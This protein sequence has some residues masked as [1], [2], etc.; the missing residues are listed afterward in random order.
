LCFFAVSVIQVL[1]AI[2]ILKAGAKCAICDLARP[3]ALP[4][5]T[6]RQQLRAGEAVQGNHSA[7]HG[8]LRKSGLAQ[9]MRGAVFSKVGPHNPSNPGQLP[10]ELKECEPVF[11]SEQFRL[12]TLLSRRFPAYLVDR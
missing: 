8:L 1:G 11:Y 10:S 4:N 6:E 2:T 12:Q 5:S 7:R 3:I 9:E